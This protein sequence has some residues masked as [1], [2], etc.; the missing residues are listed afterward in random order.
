MKFRKN[1]TLSTISEFTVVC[2]SNKFAPDATHTGPR[3]AVVK[4]S[5]YRCVSD[6]RSRSREFDLGPVAYFRGD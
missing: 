2:V 3:S 6:C 1:K 4:V 5:G